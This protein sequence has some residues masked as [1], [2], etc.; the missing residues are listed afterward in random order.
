[1]KK[2]KKTEEKK[3]EESVLSKENSIQ[4]L[5]NE[6][7]HKRI[8]TKR[9]MLYDIHA[10]IAVYGMSGLTIEQKIK[11]RELEDRLQFRILQAEEQLLD[12]KINIY[13]ELLRII[14]Q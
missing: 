7:I 1:M 8:E 6:P 3:K 2:S 13:K 11:G 10:S 9:N 14:K 12:D 5:S 4:D